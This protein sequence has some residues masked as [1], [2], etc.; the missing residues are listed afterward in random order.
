M[1]PIRRHLLPHLLFVLGCLLLPELSSQGGGPADAPRSFTET[2]RR[3][4]LQHS[5]L[6]PLPADPT[7]L[8]ADDDRAARLG[9]MLFFETRFSSGGISCASCHVPKRGFADGRRL[10]LGIAEGRRHTPSLWNVAYNR[11]FFWDGRADSLWAQALIPME[12][13]TEIGGSRLRAV[14]LL[15]EDAKL[16]DL[17]GTVFG[18][19]PDLSD[20]TRFPRDGRPVAERPDHAHSLAWS[21]MNERDRD[22]VGRV[23]SNLGKALE[24]YERRLVSRE[25]PFDRFVLGL[26]EGD[27]AKMGALSVG[28]QRGL[29]LFVGRANCR[30]CHGG[31]NFTDG[32]FHR[33]GVPPLPG[34]PADPGRYAGIDAVLRD[35][36]NGAG[37]LSDEPAGT[38]GGKLR[39]L[40]RS[41]ETWGQFK[42]PSLRNVARTAPYMHRGQLA[43]LRDVL[44][45]YATLDGVAPGDAEASLAPL[46]LTEQE[47]DDLIGFLDSLTDE[48]IDPALVRPPGEG[49]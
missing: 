6:P 17:Y 45:H 37:R 1:P 23:F 26:R 20:E 48:S 38:A 12:S 42:T 3:R 35:P 43:T 10:S 36:F 28:A 8:V 44:R 27:P 11:W 14:R 13:D 5:P 15:V 40:R 46:R 34:E 24:A 29:K 33:I 31:P 32:E 9:Q 18:P 4:V 49:P 39:Q 16:R 2:E 25:S 41:P 7:N 30:Q 21:S 19:L 47:T 22:E